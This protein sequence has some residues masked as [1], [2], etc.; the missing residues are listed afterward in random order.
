MPYKKGNVMNTKK[1]LLALCAGLLSVCT[2]CGD[3]DA[4]S[5]PS[6]DLVKC[7]QR[8][9]EAVLLLTAERVDGYQCVTVEGTLQ[10][11]VDDVR[12]RS[13]AYYLQDD[14]GLLYLRGFAETK[15]FP[16][17]T[18]TTWDNISVSGLYY[19][20][21]NVDYYQDMPL[22]CENQVGLDVESVYSD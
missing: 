3:G 14:T 11:I 17:D 5:R 21:R 22:I 12:C 18:A 6:P 4:P 19:P 8:S 20:L 1:W 16:A 15:E 10:F 13:G 7:P 9:I 2:S